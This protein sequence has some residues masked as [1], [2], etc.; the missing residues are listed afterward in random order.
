MQKFNDYIN[1]KE[2]W[3]LYNITDPKGM[4]IFGNTTGGK[5]KAFDSKMEARKRVPADGEEHD[6]DWIALEKSKYLK[7][8]EVK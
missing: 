7:L 4:V 5:F 6:P 3:V 8:K 2:E 1:E